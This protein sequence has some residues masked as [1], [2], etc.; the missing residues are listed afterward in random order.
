MSASL[1]NSL[2]ASIATVSGID[3]RFRLVFGMRKGFTSGTLRYSV[4]YN[5]IKVSNTTPISNLIADQVNTRE[6]GITVDGRYLLIEGRVNNT[7][8]PESA[9]SGNVTVSAKVEDEGVSQVAGAS[10]A[11]EAARRRCRRRAHPRLR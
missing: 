2:N 9:L 8:A 11:S 5:L 10:T 7:F 3:G 1:D 4:S 6:V